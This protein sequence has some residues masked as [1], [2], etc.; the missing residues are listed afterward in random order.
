VNIPGTT[1]FS[2]SLQNIGEVSNKGWEFVLGTVNTTGKF[3]WTTDFNLS[4]YTNRVVKL[5]PTGDPIY[6]A[7]NITMIGQPIGM[8][9]GLQRNGTFK[10]Q[11]ELNNGPIWNPGAADRSRVGDMRFVDVSGPNGKPDGIIS[12]ADYTIIGSPYPDFYYV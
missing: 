11:E 6:T 7:N 1:G 2:N 12:S 8:F 4:S 3:G 5:G 10:T 9:Y